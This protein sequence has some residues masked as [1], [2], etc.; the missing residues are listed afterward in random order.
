MGATLQSYPPL[1]Q[2]TS[3]QSPSLIFTA[4]LEIPKCREAEPWEVS[5]WLSVDGSEWNHVQLFPIEDGQ[6]PQTL[7][8]LPDSVSRLY[9][10]SPL[11]FDAS[12]QFTL[13]FRAT[14]DK[15]W[16]WIRDEQGLDDGWILRPLSITPSD[17]LS[18]LIANLNVKDWK[19]SPCLSQ[20]P[21][22]NIWALEA[23]IPAAHGDNSAYRDI[24]I[25]IPWGC[26]LR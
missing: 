17:Q 10:A 15:D 20:S 12:V 5:I 18:R 3:T 16:T 24:S 6:T 19:I 14:L 11:S 23:P 2:A 22:T 1:G 25:G 8:P 4:V 9:F 26:L 13:R 21:R 7:Q